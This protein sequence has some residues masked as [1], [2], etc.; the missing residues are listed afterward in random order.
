MTA[1]RSILAAVLAVLALPLAPA[2]VTAL[3]QADRAKAY[4]HFLLGRYLEN[5]GDVRGAVAALREAASRDPA[6]AE[7]RAEL[8]AL[9]ARQ[10]QVAEATKWGQAAL[11]IEPA[12]VE[13]HRVLGFVAASQVRLEARGSLAEP[14]AMA[15]AAGAIA[16]LE[17]ARRPNLVPDGGI[18]L[19]LA[20]L[21]LRTGSPEQAIEVLGRMA[22]WEPERPPVVLMLAEAYE[23]AGQLDKAAVNLQRAAEQRPRDSGL[24][25][26]LGDLLFR[27]GR[28]G[29]AVSAWERALAGDGERVNREGIERKIQAARE[30][31]PRR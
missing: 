13:A 30:R 5:E 16:H 22:L 25:D 15:V 24:L 27:L 7:I 20:R 14:G 9:H 6:S 28:Y 23:A 12:N 29:Q 26:H 4:Y 31:T 11:A 17:A 10:D 2:P 8:A 19:T 1:Q 3:P 21:Y 18:E